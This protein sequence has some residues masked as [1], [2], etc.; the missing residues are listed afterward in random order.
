MAEYNKVF[1]IEKGYI[2]D[3]SMQNHTM[4]IEDEVLIYNPLED[5][6]TLRESMV[7]DFQPENDEQVD[8]SNL[9]EAQKL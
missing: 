5:E 7:V 9:D 3:E 8:E 6:K 2:F 4:F 1:K